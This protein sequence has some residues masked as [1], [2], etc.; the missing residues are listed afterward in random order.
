VHL[1]KE[2][3]LKLQVTENYIQREQFILR[4]TF[5]ESNFHRE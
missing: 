2:R 1:K 4:I 3:G 5:A